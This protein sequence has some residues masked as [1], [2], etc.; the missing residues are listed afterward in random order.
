MRPATSGAS[1]NSVRSQLEDLF[2]FEDPDWLRVDGLVEGEPV[3]EQMTFQI[4]E[5]DAFVPGG[6]SPLP[7]GRG[8]S[9]AW[10]L[11]PWTLERVVAG[12][13]RRAF[14]ART[15]SL[16]YALPEEAD[17]IFTAA[18]DQGWTRIEVRGNLGSPPPPSYLWD[19]ILEIAQVRLHDGGVPEGEADVRF[20]LR[21]VPTGVDTASIERSI[22]ANLADDPRALLGI[23]T[24]ILDTTVGAADF[25]YYRVEDGPADQRGDWL[26]F[27]APG[28]IPTGEDGAPA[29]A[30]AYAA[31]GFYADARLTEKVSTTAPVDGDTEHEK[32]RIAQGDVLYLGDDAGAVYEL[33]IGDKP[34][35]GRRAMTIT[36]V[37]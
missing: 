36:R 21:D 23:T 32:V 34:S 8:D 20:T 7:S 9:R 25:Y 17:P 27:I 1:V 18:I 31:P 37:R 6:R 28:D 4:V 30:Y 29:R 15:A 11:A 2:D 16:S 19:A 33:A 35:R 22:R 3:I 10:Q 13:A 5:E 26:F 14:D 12:A 24:E